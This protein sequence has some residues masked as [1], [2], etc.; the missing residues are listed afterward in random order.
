MRALAS[1]TRAALLSSGALAGHALV[2]QLQRLLGNACVLLRDAHGFLRGG[3]VEEGRDHGRA[4]IGAGRAQVGLRD[5]ARQSGGLDARARLPPVSIGMLSVVV[6]VRDA[7]RRSSMLTSMLGLGSR[8]A[9][10]NSPSVAAASL[11]AAASRDCVRRL[12]TGPVPASAARWR[13]WIAGGRNGGRRRRQERSGRLAPGRR[14]QQGGRQGQ[15][16]QGWAHDS[17][18]KG[19]AGPRS[20]AGIG[21]WRHCIERASSEPRQKNDISVRLPSLPWVGAKP[22]NTRVSGQSRRLRRNRRVGEL[23]RSDP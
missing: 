13:G 22:G 23:T 21:I 19:V 20:R 12:W 3:H 6:V 18:R 16:Y 2:G 8:P 9:C 11:R 4:Q 7:L 14:G 15:R 1:S 17:V 5:V 10:C